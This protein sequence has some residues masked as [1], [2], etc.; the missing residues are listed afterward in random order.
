MGRDVRLVGVG[1][2]LLDASTAKKL[3]LGRAAPHDGTA[4]RPYQADD[5]TSFVSTSWSPTTPV[6]ETE[7]P[8]SPATNSRSVMHSSATGSMTVTTD[9]ADY[10]PGSTATF[11]VNGVGSGSLVEFKIA[12]FTSDPGINGIADVYSPFTVADGGTGDA[13]GIANGTVVAAWQ[14][15]ADGRATGA[16]LQLAAT[17]NG[18]TAITTFS[19]A[20]NAIVLENMLPGNPESEWLV[21]QSDP[22]IEGF[23]AQFSVNHGQ[24]ID[25]KINTNSSHYRIDIYRLGY[26]NGDG[27]RKVAT[28]DQTL[29]TPQVQPAPLFDPTTNLVDAGNWSVSASWAIPANAVSGV[30]VAKLTRLDGSGGASMIPFVVRDD[31]QPSDMTFQ[32]SDE[33]W[34]AY[35]EW[36]GYNVYGGPTGRATAVSYNR[37]FDNLND[38]AEGVQSFLFADEY[39]AIRW[40]EPWLRHELHLGS[41]TAR[42]AAQLLNTKVFLSV[43]HEEYWSAEQRANVQAARD[44]GVNLAFL[45]GNTMFWETRWAPSTDASATP[46]RT[47]ITY[48]ET[49]DKQIVTREERQ[50]LGVIRISAPVSRKTHSSAPSTWLTRRGSIRSPFPI[51]CPIS[52]F[53]RIPLSAIWSL[54]KSTR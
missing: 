31:N 7:P 23:T 9:Q 43:G 19:D 32:T 47:I 51:A 26:Y 27:A 40:F 5:L 44:A 49:L 13:D 11:V 21:N 52:G 36:G 12:D 10:A 24:T 3:Q 14:V 53:G 48:K 20:P 22:T 8:P 54:V 34:E 30:Y 45:S 39:A 15:P 16:L 41:D 37:P 6:L 33:T 28:I 2:P 17:S 42:D 35:N 29:A 1:S 25:F 4:S 50:E 18:R 38:G 46:Y